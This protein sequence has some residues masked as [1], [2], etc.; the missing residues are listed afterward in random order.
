MLRRAAR[1]QIHPTA[2][3]RAHFT[4]C[5]CGLYSIGSARMLRDKRACNFREPRVEILRHKY[6][7]VTTDVIG[8]D[9]ESDDD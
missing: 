8:S 3:I 2:G 5:R 7:F 4:R 6:R 9:R 1:P